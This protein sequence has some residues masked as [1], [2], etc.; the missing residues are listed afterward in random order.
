[1]IGFARESPHL[2]LGTS[3]CWRGRIFRIRVVGLGGSTSWCASREEPDSTPGP[4]FRRRTRVARKE[5]EEMKASRSQQ[6][7]ILR[8]GII[9]LAIIIA[10]AWAQ[11]KKESA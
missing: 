3:P 2:P 8:W 11:N 5:E 6:M 9:I 1:M 4:T 10:P 7:S